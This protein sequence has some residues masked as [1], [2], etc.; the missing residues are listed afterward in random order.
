VRTDF[1]IL[2]VREWEGAAAFRLLNSREKHG[3]GFSR[4]PFAT[5]LYAFVPSSHAHTEGPP[6]L[7]RSTSVLATLRPM[8]TR[9]SVRLDQ[10]TRLLLEDLKLRL[11]WSYSK[12]IREG[13][14]RLA[15][16]QTLSGAIRKSCRSVA[17]N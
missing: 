15:A 11:G 12:I 3:S 9:V 5:D 7:P 4:G 13:I 1:G 8:A 16:Q 6:Y 10:E 17:D 14:L 2:P